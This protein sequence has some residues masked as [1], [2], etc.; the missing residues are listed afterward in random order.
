MSAFTASSTPNPIL[1][2]VTRGPLVESVHRGSAVAMRA[3]GECV[4]VWGDADL[5]TYPR[6]AN[7]PL[8]A[9]P[10][11]ETGAATAFGLGAAEIALACSSHWGED[12]HV[13]TVRA[14]LK[15]IGLTE[16][17]LECGAHWPYA[18]AAMLA[19]ARSGGEPTAA[20]NNCSGKHTGF[21]TTAVHLKEDPRGYVAWDHPVQR[22]ITATLSEMYGVDC[23]ASPWGV[24]GC[25]IPTIAVPL[26]NLALGMARLADPVGQGTVRAESCRAIVSAM[27]V[28]PFMVSGTG[29]YTTDVMVAI[30]D[31]VVVKIGAEGVFTAALRKHGIGVAIKVDDGAARGAELALGGVLRA[32]GVMTPETDAAIQRLLSVP[33]RNRAGLTV[34]ELRPTA[35]TP[36][37]IGAPIR[38]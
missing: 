27:A 28:E 9:L 6:S 33:I 13:V 24:D 17:A 11:L 29:Q 36:A 3:N 30:G 35:L 14:W 22:R 8:Q 38:F 12:R 37:G 4:A 21:L 18:E 16:A 5:V 2:E 20:H 26:K 1:V 34:G 7:K 23:A 25:G 15:R 32:L 19:L 31:V 10:L